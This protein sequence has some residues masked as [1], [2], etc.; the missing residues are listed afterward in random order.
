M[1]TADELTVSTDMYVLEPWGPKSSSS[2]LSRTETPVGDGGVVSGV[3]SG[4]VASEGVVS[5]DVV[6]GGVTS[7]GA[8][9]GGSADKM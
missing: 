8:V 5:G 6:G 3:V 7:K 1:R 4:G 2:S 9:S